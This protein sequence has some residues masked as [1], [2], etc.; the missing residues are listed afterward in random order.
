MRCLFIH[1]LPCASFATYRG[2]GNQCPH[3][4]ECSRP[5]PSDNGRSTPLEVFAI[6]DGPCGRSVGD[7]GMCGKPQTNYLWIAGRGFIGS[8]RRS[9]EP[10]ALVPEIRSLKPDALLL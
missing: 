10:L 9:T 1:D 7:S 5:G 2:L 4:R 8:V 6:F 3:V